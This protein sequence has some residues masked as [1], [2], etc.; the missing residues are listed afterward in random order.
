MTKQA[1]FEVLDYILLGTML[2]GSMAIGLYFSLAGKRQRT[3]EE[4]L[5][6][7]RR[8]TAI[9][10]CLSLFATFQSAISLLG[11]PN[12]VYTYGTMYIYD[13]ISTTLSNLLAM[14]TVV[15]LI[16]PL[17]ITSVNEYLGLRYDS[18]VVQ[19]VGAV[20]G[21]L[22]SLSYMTIALLSPA[23]ALEPTVGIPLWLSI[24]IVGGVG[25]VYTTIGGIKSVIWADVFQTV[26]IFAGAFT[27]LAKGTMNVGGIEKVW[28]IGH[29]TG[30]ITLDEISFD[31]RVRHTVWGFTFGAMIYWYSSFYTQVS[32]QRILS[33]RC[34][35]DVR[36]VYII[37]IVLTAVYSS[38]LVLTGLVLT[39][40]FHVTKCD[41][42]AAD[43][44]TNNN[45]L[46]PYFVLLTLRF[47]PGLSGLYIAT[48]F[49]AS[50]STLSS[51]INALAANTVEDFISKILR[52]KSE[53][54]MTTITKAL[55]CFY[56]LTCIG[57]AY[58]AKELQGPVTQMTFMA[59]GAVAG[60][61]L[62]MFILGASFPQANYIGA[63]VGCAAGVSISF[64]LAIGAF[65]FGHPT[66]ALPPGPTDNCSQENIT[67][68][69][70]NYSI[71]LTTQSTQ[72]MPTESFITT[73][74]TSAESDSKLQDRQ[75]SIF[76]V[77][78]IWHPVLGVI[79]TIA[80]GLLTSVIVSRFMRQK[81][82]PEAKFLFP[83][84]RKLW[85]SGSVL[86]TS[87]EIDDMDGIE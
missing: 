67:S 47:I 5:L 15:P 13:I 61:L 11:T 14:V 60:P 45:Q 46:V 4:Y 21:V 82:R 77:S 69:L 66:E 79:T 30:R 54:V 31:P 64:G 72:A 53:A 65:R 7:G 33:T 27:V 38:I 52:N 26:F 35:E 20:L 78:Y 24:V 51:G 6:G 71:L 44:I 50:L 32:V 83:I 87:I 56:G 58:L 73:A 37:S 28:D 40:Y 1:H 84:C 48:I 12:E 22:T 36:K 74:S 19:V 86:E 3:K 34:I 17:K 10:V 23:L 41:P 49:S 80:V 75:L 18:A 62:G 85:N 29:A 9:P 43:F 16:Y 8:M 42:L 68:L 25:T 76:D 63:L 55:V 39:A 81:H 2:C 57:L 70:T 59:V